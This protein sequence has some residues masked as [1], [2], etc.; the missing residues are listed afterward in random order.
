MAPPHYEKRVDAALAVGEHVTYLSDD[1]CMSVL[2][3]VEMSAVTCTNI[4]SSADMGGI[5]AS[6]NPNDRVSPSIG[7]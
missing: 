2:A 6:A 4:M 5:Y 1:K 7:L 3:V